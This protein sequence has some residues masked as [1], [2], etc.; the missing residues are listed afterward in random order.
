MERGYKLIEDDIRPEYDLRNV[1]VLRMGPLRRQ[2][3]NTIRLEPDVALEFCDSDSVNETLRRLICV[4][5]E[6]LMKLNPESDLSDELR[7]EYT[8]ADLKTECVANTWG[9][10]TYLSRRPC[11]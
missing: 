8:E 3:G 1:R 6:N 11:S 5:Q 4:T 10:L 7:P 2:F 9:G